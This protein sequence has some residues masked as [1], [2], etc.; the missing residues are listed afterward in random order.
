MYQGTYN[1]SGK[2]WRKMMRLGNLG[3]CYQ[4]VRGRDVILPIA[5]GLLLVVGVALCM[6]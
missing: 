3:T 2:E 4:D 1:V 6:A 5:L